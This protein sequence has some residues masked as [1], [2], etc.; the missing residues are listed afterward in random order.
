MSGPSIRV[1]QGGNA[2]LTSPAN[3][4]LNPLQDRPER[5]IAS[6]LPAQH[7]FNTPLVIW[8]LQVL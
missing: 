8:N 2:P 4:R 7:Q 1:G 3:Y 6:A 5:L